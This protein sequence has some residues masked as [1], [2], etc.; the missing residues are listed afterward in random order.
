MEESHLTCI[1]LYLAMR[2]AGRCCLKELQG[3]KHSAVHLHARFSG[4]S[5][6]GPAWVIYWDPV[7][8]AKNKKNQGHLVCQKTVQY[9]PKHFPLWRARQNFIPCTVL[10]LHPATEL[11]QQHQIFKNCKN[12]SGE[13]FVYNQNP[14]QQ[15]EIVLRFPS[16]VSE[17]RFQTHPE[18]RWVAGWRWSAC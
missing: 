7:S 11:K 4:G 10:G 12:K 6:R 8:N 14:T 17:I 18:V 9:L 5:G 3:T 2:K 13:L 15:L 16:V 1:H